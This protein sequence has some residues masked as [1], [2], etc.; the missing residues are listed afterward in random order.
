MNSIPRTALAALALSAICAI[1]PVALIASPA[2]DAATAQFG[3][4]PS[5]DEVVSILTS[6]LALTDEQAHSIAPI[7]ADRQ[8]QIK[9]ILGDSSSGK[10]TQ[11]RLAR[12]VFEDSDGKI[13]AILTPQQ[14]DGYAAFE[15]QMREQM[16]Q[17][18]KNQ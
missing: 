3:P 9:A 18:M 16:R 17:R 4:I 15:K 12:K 7:I 11:R 13:N 14:R 8:Q 2:E 10:M 5:P 6:K 1:T